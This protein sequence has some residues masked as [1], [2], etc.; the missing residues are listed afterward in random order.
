MQ[1]R[2]YYIA[3]LLAT[4]T[5]AS[6][7]AK[8]NKES[9]AKN[10]SRLS[11]GAPKEITRVKS[12]PIKGIY[13]VLYDGQVFYS[14]KTGSY[15]LFGSLLDLTQAAPVDLTA[16]A[17]QTVTKQ[18]L[19][20][21]PT[22]ETLVYKVTNGQKPKHVLTVFTDID[23][24]YCRK[25]HQEVPALNKAG[26]EVHYAAFPRAGV[27]SNSYKKINEVWCSNNPQQALTQAKTGQSY[28]TNRQ[29]NKAKVINHH[30]ELVRKLGINGTPTLFFDN[31]KKIPGY[32]PANRLI[33]EI[34][35]S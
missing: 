18:I 24:G 34:N 11:Q 29:C 27:G 10:L 16:Q 32:L 19:A 31:G 21:L 14:N 4:I 20:E 35:K 17:K 28:K 25:F 5:A 8:P 23:C 9:I 7:V 6:V 3:L 13:E 1:A 26:I 2:K 12:T 33:Q 15:I 22:N 30:M